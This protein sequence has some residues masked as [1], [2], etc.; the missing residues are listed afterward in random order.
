M[1]KLRDE[2]FRKDRLQRSGTWLVAFLADWCPFCQHFRP[3]LSTL[4]SE[5]G[6]RAAEGDLTSMSSPLWDEFHID[7]VPTVVVFRE[8]ASVF[9]VDGVLGEGLPPGGLERAR[10]AAL[11]TPG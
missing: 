5:K 2:A 4:E 7:V 11:R 1:E 3:E 6:F 9:R 8:G 10:Q